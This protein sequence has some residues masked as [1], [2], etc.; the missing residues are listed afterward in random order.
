ME[1]KKSDARLDG[2]FKEMNFIYEFVIPLF[3]YIY[4]SQNDF[5]LLLFFFFPLFILFRLKTELMIIDI[6]DARASRRLTVV[7]LLPSSFQLLSPVFTRLRGCLSACLHDYPHLSPHHP[8]TSSASSSTLLAP[9]SLKYSFRSSL[10]LSF[11]I[12]FPSPFLLSF[13]YHI[14]PTH[15]SSLNSSILLPS[16]SSFLSLSSFLFALLLPLPPFRFFSL[17]AYILLPP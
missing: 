7:Q 6:E 14:H 16:N 10:F 8:V 11:R 4:S 2:S 15:Q 13:F 12:S 17:T 1:R 5:S 3:S 9:P